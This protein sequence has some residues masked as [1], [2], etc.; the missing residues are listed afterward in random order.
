MVLTVRAVL[1]SLILSYV[2]IMGL[3]ITTSNLLRLVQNNEGNWLVDIPYSTQWVV[4]LKTLRANLRLDDI[5][6]IKK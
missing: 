4:L 3:T 5:Q 1:D 6:K 2:R